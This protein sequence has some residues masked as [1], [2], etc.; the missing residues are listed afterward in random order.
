MFSAT[1]VVGSVQNLSFLSQIFGSN[2]I[3]VSSS[4]ST[5]TTTLTFASINPLSISSRKSLV[6]H[7]KPYFSNTKLSVS[8]SSNLE[9]EDGLVEQ[10]EEGDVTLP[11]T[12]D[13]GRQ[14]RSAYWKAARAYKE[15][16]AIYEAKIEGSNSGGLLVRFFSLQ[17][18]LPYPLLSPSHYCKEPHK[19][20][21]DIGKDLVGSIISVKVIQ[22]S[23]ESRNLIFSEREAIWSKYSER[24]EVGDVFIG[25]VGSLEDYGAF[26]HLRFPDGYYHITGMVHISEISWDLVQDVRDVLNEGDEVK[27]K[28]IQLDRGKAR[29][30]LSIKQLEDDPLLETL[31]KVIPEKGQINTNS[32]DTLNNSSIEPLPGLDSICKELLQEKGITDVRIS[33]Q[34]FEKR[35]VSQDLQLW[36]SNEPAVGNQFT[37]LARAGRQVQEIQLITTLNQEGVKKALQRVL[38]RVP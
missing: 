2:S 24:I 5:T 20:I 32:S 21:Q 6:L 7:H 35:V 23:E 36:L 4:C 29:V 8:I 37:L 34:G 14:S 28:V 3:D 10:S 30:T 15:S 13:S 19:S 27:V 38:E 33:R 12:T 25:R 26:V 18:F 11:T 9:T 22:A 17:G 1:P 31:D 16:G